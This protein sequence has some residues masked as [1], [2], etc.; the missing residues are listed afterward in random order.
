MNEEK[1]IKGFNNGYV[2]AEHKPELLKAVTQNLPPANEYVEGILDGK[3]QFKLEKT[4]EQI[5]EIEQLRN[6]T[7]SKENELSK[8]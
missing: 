2:L 5:S 8:E 1:Y 4:Q 3:E 6:R 7:G